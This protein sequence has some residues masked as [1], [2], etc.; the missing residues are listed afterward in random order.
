MV[1]KMEKKSEKKSQLAVKDQAIAVP[2]IKNLRRKTEA[3]EVAGRHKNDGQMAH[4][5]AR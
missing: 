1:K 2:E 4:K 5:G 3:K